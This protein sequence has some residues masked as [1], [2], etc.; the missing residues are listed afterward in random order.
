VVLNDGLPPQD[1]RTRTIWWALLIAVGFTAICTI[2]FIYSGLYNVAADVPH[3]RPVYAVLEYVRERSISRRAAE[4]PVPDLK[5]AELIRQG[6]GNYDAMCMGCH[7]SPG[8][9][10]TE[11]S[12]GLYPAPPA[13]AR[14]NIADPAETFWVIKHGVKGTGMPAWG[15]SMD[16]HY[17][18]GTVAFLRVLPTLDES[19]YRKLVASSSGHS[20]GGGETIEHEHRDRTPDASAGSA[21][22]QPDS[23]ETAHSHTSDGSHDHPQT[24]TPDNDSD[25]RH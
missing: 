10:E 21:V 20:H 3:T 6:A 1:R 25:H 16:D 8:M 7:L 19:G 18:W 5:D 13:L 17:I 12:K 15:R 22:T 24:E 23:P 11:L 9:S 14:K 2:L 4:L